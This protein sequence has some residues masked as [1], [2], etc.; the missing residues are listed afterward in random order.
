MKYHYTIIL[1]LLIS[2]CKS[3][4]ELL[5]KGNYER[6]FTEAMKEIQ[7]DKNVEENTEVARIAS[8]EISTNSLKAFRKKSRSHD[9]DVWIDGQTQ[10]F[11]VL[12][13]IG[14]A[15]AELDGQLNESY[16]ALCTE[17]KS[18][19]YRIVEHYYNE[20][21]DYFDAFDRTDQKIEARNAYYSFKNCDK[22]EGQTYFP[23][24]ALDIDAA[25]QNG[26]VYYTS[27]SLLSTQLFLKPLPAGA[28]FGADCRISISHGFVSYSTSESIHNDKKTKNI[29]TGKETIVDTSGITTYKPIYEDI[30]ATIVTKTITV[31]AQVNTNIWSEDLTGNCTVATRN[32]ITTLDDS[33][34]EV[35][36]VGDERALY[37]I[38]T[39][40]SGEPAFFRSN[41]ESDLMKKANNAIGL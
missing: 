31:T 20:G 41:L 10:L 7:K 8:Q 12:E 2:S 30:E 22:Y 14:A 39:K 23:D 18:I 33:Y 13:K 38:V 9:V 1:L 19:D 4:T 17:K 32:I 37:H 35:S 21:H 25:Y 26:I 24:L 36:V 16:D 34:D 27:S 40:S 28:D 5:E 6:A 3:P 15:N 29:E 11:E